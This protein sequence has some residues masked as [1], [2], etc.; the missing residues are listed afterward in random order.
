MHIFRVIRTVR[1]ISSEKTSSFQAQNPSTSL[2]TVFF[3][4]KRRNEDWEDNVKV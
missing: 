1:L 2:N 4:L 3:I